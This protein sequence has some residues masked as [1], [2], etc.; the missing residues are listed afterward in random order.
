MDQYNL[1][2]R[3]AAWVVE[4]FGLA[5]AGDKSERNH[6]FLEESLEL[7]QS[8][9]CGRREAEQLVE[10]VYN[11]PSGLP[12]QEVGGVMVTLFALCQA[13]KL[14]ALECCDIELARCYEKIE[15]IRKKQAT[16][17]GDSPIPEYVRP[18]QYAETPQDLCA[19]RI[20]GVNPMA[21]WRNGRRYYHVICDVDCAN[22][23]VNVGVKQL[24]ISYPEFD[25]TKSNP[26]LQRRVIQNTAH[27]LWNKLNAA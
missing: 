24:K 4:A 22:L 11:R 5:A 21:C 17:P 25:Y 18:A 2:S 10:Y 16:K 8:L 13:S 3:V 26:T 6:R 1:Q 19:C 9:G 27:I 20:C 14:D 15:T 23:G 7:V 12:A